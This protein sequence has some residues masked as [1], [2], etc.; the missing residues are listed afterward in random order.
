VR[1][2]RHDLHRLRRER[3]SESG[4]DE[5]EGRSG[6]RRRTTK[7]R[8]R[9]RRRRMTMKQEEEEEEEERRRRRR[10]RRKRRSKE[11][12]EE[13]GGTNE[14]NN[15][16]DEGLEEPMEPRESELLLIGSSFFGVSIREEVEDRRRGGGE[17]GE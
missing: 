11:E 13:R 8:R 12:D 17:E 3:E 6:L 10:R 15:G 7:R 16:V 1:D 5:G 2:R 4:R 14:G 9:R